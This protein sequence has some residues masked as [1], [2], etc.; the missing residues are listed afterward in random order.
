MLVALYD[1]TSILE[2]Q[3]TLAVCPH[4]ARQ[5]RQVFLRC[6]LLLLLGVFGDLLVFDTFTKREA[7]RAR[8]GD[9]EDRTATAPSE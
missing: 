6:H 1:V 5:D 3:I 9:F 4:I 7:V 2:N 8:D